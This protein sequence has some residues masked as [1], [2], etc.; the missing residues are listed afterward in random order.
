MAKETFLVISYN[1]ETKKFQY[2]DDDTMLLAE[3]SDGDTWDSDTEQFSYLTY[4]AFSAIIDLLV[5]Q[6]D[7]N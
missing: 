1:H 3:R 2:E 6:Q 4:E 5:E 7:N